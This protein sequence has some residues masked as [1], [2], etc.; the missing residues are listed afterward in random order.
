MLKLYANENFPLPVVE[1]LRRL[2]C[3]VTTVQETGRAGQSWPDEEVLGYATAEGR[4]V[5]TLNRKHFLR[6]HRADAKHAGIVVCTADLD[7]SA[8][9]RRIHSALQAA[10][11]PR[12]QLLRVNRPA[13]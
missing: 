2:G 13:S 7:F 6:L 8:Q 9:A 1:E 12:G 10:G 4:A 3:D 5:V 11:D